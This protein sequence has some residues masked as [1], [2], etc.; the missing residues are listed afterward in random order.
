MKTIQRITFCSLSVLIIELAACT[1]ISSSE[2]IVIEDQDCTHSLLLEKSTAPITAEQAINVV[3]LFD[4]ENHIVTKSN[5]A[6]ISDV[7]T[8]FN[9]EGVPVFYAVNRGENNGYIIV[10]ASRKYYPILAIVEKGHFDNLY[11]EM[12]LSSWVEEQCALITAFEKGEYKVLDCEA[13]WSAYEKTEPMLFITTKTEEEALALKQ[14]SITAW[15]AQGY[16]CYALQ[17]CPD[18]L[19]SGTYNQWL[20]LASV[21]ANPDYDYLYFSVILEKYVEN[22]STT[23]PLIGSSWDQSNGFNAAVPNNCLVGCVPVAIGQI[24]WFFE[25]PSTFFWS[26]M[27]AN[28]ATSTTASFLYTLGCLMGIDYPHNDSSASH[29]DGENALNYYGYSTS[30]NSY[31]EA[32]VISNIAMGKPVYI[33]GDVQGVN[34]GHAW[35]CEGSRINQH[36]Y[37]YTLKILDDALPLAYTNAGQTCY[38]GYGTYNYLYHNL[39]YGGS[40]NGWYMGSVVSIKGTFL[41]NCMI[42]NITP[43]TN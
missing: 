7:Y 14:A 29:G 27:Y 33:G 20:S 39:G 2:S 15:E 31:N 40:G 13:S 4:L 19:P 37:E 5:T 10:S 34:E 23:G 21:S 8:H 26:D 28:S 42:Y 3:K 18:Y 17:D 36:H 30:F 25:K 32:T 6:A 11:S 38:S 24:M 22:V 9:L 35:V 41:P 43:P 12:G 1:S 16:T